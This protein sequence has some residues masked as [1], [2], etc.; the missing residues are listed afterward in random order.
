[1][2]CRT[3]I[4]DGVHHLVNENTSQP[5][6]SLASKDLD[7]EPV[8]KIVYIMG[9]ARSGSTILDL[10]LGQHTMISSMGEIA[11]IIDNK[12]TTGEVCGCGAS[13]EACPF[14]RTVRG[15]LQEN[16]GNAAC[17]R[18]KV[19]TSTNERIRSIPR[20]LSRSRHPE[21]MKEATYPSDTA[22]LLRTIAASAKAPILVDSSKHPGRALALATIPGLDV[23]LIHLV[24]DPR[25]VATSLAKPWKRDLKKGIQSDMPGRSPAKSAFSWMVANLAAE[26]VAKYFSPSK[27]IRVRYEDLV[28]STDETLAK[29][30][31]TAGLDLSELSKFADGSLQ[32]KTN[33]LLA[34]N[35]SR[36]AGTLELRADERWRT[37]LPSDD[38]RLV[39]IITSPLRS[40]YG[41]E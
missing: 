26:S 27:R 24:R 21:D 41:Y 29:L 15:A 7:T 31:S 32:P 36:L 18:L 33:H 12:E 35:R 23:R 11:H 30:S 8:L 17:D 1:M 19:T 6:L 13:I 5:A 16:G 10:L 14:W 25:G 38:R 2:T 4:L 39:E 37:D 34:G 3:R 9:S 40:A 28:T 22:L 20:T